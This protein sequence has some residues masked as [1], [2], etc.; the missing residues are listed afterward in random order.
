MGRNGWKTV[1]LDNPEDAATLEAVAEDVDEV[2]VADKAISSALDGL[3]DNSEEAVAVAQAEVEEARQREERLGNLYQEAVD[4]ALEINGR[5][6]PLR[7]EL[8][9]DARHSKRVQDLENRLAT[10]IEN[11]PEDHMKGSLQKRIDFDTLIKRVE[12]DVELIS[13]PEWEGNPWRI[14][15]KRAKHAVKIGY[16]REATAEEQEQINAREFQGNWL[17][18]GKTVYVPERPGSGMGKTLM[19]VLHQLRIAAGEESE[20]FH[21]SQEALADYRA[22]RRKELSTS[23]E[24]VQ[25]LLDGEAVIVAGTFPWTKRSRNGETAVEEYLE[26]EGLGGGAFRV[27]D[28]NAFGNLINET[29]DEEHPA[30]GAVFAALTRLRERLDGTEDERAEQERTLLN[31]AQ[32][33]VGEVTDWVTDG[34]DSG[35]DGTFAFGDVQLTRRDGSPGNT[36]RGVIAGQITGES[37]VVT[38]ATDAAERFLTDKEGNPFVGQEYRHGNIPGRLFGL[39]RNAENAARTE[40]EEESTE[41]TSSEETEVD[42]PAADAVSEETDEA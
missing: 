39:L 1:D 4:A 16:L 12:R 36:V 13:S 19:D 9:H 3:D 38:D 6:T 41:E 21:E 42:E 5:L 11:L 24:D 29:V 23:A 30:R 14:L 10:V 15:G 2:D 7:F 8:G 35:V 22:Q 27:I 25:R 40:A 28:G 37:V 34:A 32:L 20:R 31:S 18:A 17:R 33:S 26:V